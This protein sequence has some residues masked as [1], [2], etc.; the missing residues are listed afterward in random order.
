MRIY[1]FT[2]DHPKCWIDI[3]RMTDNASVNWMAWGSNQERAITRADATRTSP[4]S[5]TWPHEEDILAVLP[6]SVAKEVL[7]GHN[8]DGYPTRRIPSDPW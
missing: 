4:T 8:S 1:R 6:N 5:K 7:K 2:D 3:Q